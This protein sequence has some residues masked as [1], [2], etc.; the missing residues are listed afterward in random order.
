MQKIENSI[1]HTSIQSHTYFNHTH[2][3]TEIESKR[4]KKRNQ[5]SLDFKHEN[6]SQLY[7]YFPVTNQIFLQ[8]NAQIVSTVSF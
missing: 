6:E 5:Q 8:N 4:M 3:S 7:A 1:T 2:S